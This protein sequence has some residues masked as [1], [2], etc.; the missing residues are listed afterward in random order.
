MYRLNMSRRSYRLERNKSLRGLRHAYTV[1]KNEIDNRTFPAPISSVT[2][3]IVL[4][5]AR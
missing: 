1:L 4:W 3:G 2:S 5:V